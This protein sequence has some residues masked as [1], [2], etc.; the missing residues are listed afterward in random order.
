MACSEKLAGFDTQREAFLG[1]YRGWEAPAAV[2]AGKT[3]DSIACG[4]QPIGAQHVRVSLEPG[5]QKKII[6][7]LGY[8]ENP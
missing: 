8:H 5:E 3:S 6:F 7:L 1:A 4:W 2:E